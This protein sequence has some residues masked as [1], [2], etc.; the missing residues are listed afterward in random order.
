MFSKYSLQNLCEDLEKKL[1]LYRTQYQTVENIA[2][3]YYDK[4]SHITKLILK[5]NN[6]NIEQI[7]TELQKAYGDE[8]SLNHNQLNILQTGEVDT[9]YSR[10]YIELYQQKESEI[11]NKFKGF[12]T[13]KICYNTW[14]HLYFDTHEIQKNFIDNGSKYLIENQNIQWKQERM[15]AYLNK[16]RTLRRDFNIHDIP[17]QFDNHYDIYTFFSKQNIHYFLELIGDYFNKVI[18]YNIIE[19]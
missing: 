19:L 13:D 1:T 3:L 2:K 14:F 10:I 6:D 8:I 15:N 18:L 12:T 4:T 5:I 11:F 17:K 7:A 9:I 16:Y